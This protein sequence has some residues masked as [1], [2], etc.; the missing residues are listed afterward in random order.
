VAILLTGDLETE[1]EKR[2][3]AGGFD[4]QSIVLKA[5]HHGSSTAS[6]DG[7][8]REV[9]PRV[10]LVSCGKNNRFHHPHPAT[11][12]R[13]TARGIEIQR[14]DEKGAVTI[15]T[16]GEKYLIQTAK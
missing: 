14:T 12:Q 16:D 4:L 6:S 3:M 11:L 2:V 10:A 9:S 7:F 1:G 13:L 8:L 15:R 5:G